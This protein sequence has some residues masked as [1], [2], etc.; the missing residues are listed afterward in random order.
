[1]SEIV[2]LVEDAPEGGLVARA[3]GHAIFTEADSYDELR[4]QV[5]DAVQCHF[6]VNERPAMIRLHYVKDEVLAA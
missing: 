5:R 1:M 2:F 4:Q 6:E 3:L